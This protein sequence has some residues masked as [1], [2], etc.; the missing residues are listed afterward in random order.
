[1]KIIP[2]TK[3]SLIALTLF[4]LIILCDKTSFA[5]PSKIN[6][7][8]RTYEMVTPFCGIGFPA[9]HGDIIEIGYSN[10]ICLIDSDLSITFGDYSYTTLVYS[11][12][13]ASSE[14]ERTAINFGAMFYRG[15]NATLTSSTSGT[16]PIVLYEKEKMISNN[17][18][19]LINIGIPNPFGFGIKYYL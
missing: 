3:N 18:A 17:I 4:L 14:N 5:M 13:I 7:Q 2:F 10:F 16:K 8:L 15:T 9:W 11:K 12:Q 1:L 19:V 6:L